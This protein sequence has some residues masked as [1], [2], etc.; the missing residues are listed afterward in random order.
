MSAHVVTG[1]TGFIG[2]A[3]VLELLQWTDD[4]V[5]ALV[6]PGPT[7][8]EARLREALARAARAYELEAVL[9]S[10]G[11][12]V[13]AVAGDITAP[14]CGAQG[15]I[16][17]RGGQMWH[18]AASLR[19][20]DRHV[21]EIRATNVEGTR[22][23]L[24]LAQRIG[25]EAFNH[26]STAY[27]A[28][29]TCGVVLEEILP[30]VETCNLYERSKV[31]AE[32]L[33]AAEPGLCKRLLRPGIVVGHSRTRAATTFSGFYGFIRQ[34][35]QFAGAVHRAQE[36][37]LTRAPLRMRVD[38]ELGLGMIPIDSVA[39]QAAQIGLDPAAQGVFHLT[40]PSP[41]A[42]G[43]AIRAVFRALELH[44]PRFVADRAE[45]EWLD[46]RLDQRLGFYGS[47][48]IGERRF[49]RRRSDAR[50]GGAP[51]LEFDDATLAA[52]IDWYL[53]HLTRERACLP[54]AR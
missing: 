23:A 3:L 35:L 30:E 48:L 50:T 5:I 4:E 36:G 37:L 9:A 46:E 15:P 10:E 47:Y 2:A 6:R 20:E 29:R 22:H 17:A 32:R 51:E 49:D 27:V 40:H 24:A 26:V 18:C 43:R 21:A 7:G 45:F 8:A 39:R 28:G 44:E 13:R 1:A 53:P 42:V 19:Y 52:F 16:A 38:A 12:R 25:V 34:T 31:D 11:G 14:G 54:T 33:V 41:P